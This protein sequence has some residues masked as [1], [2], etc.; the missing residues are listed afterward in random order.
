MADKRCDRCGK[1]AISSEF[2]FN[3]FPGYSW[4]C[5]D[6]GTQLRK[7]KADK[8]KQTKEI[9]ELKKEQLEMKKELKKANETTYKTTR[10]T[11]NTTSSGWWSD[12]T[13]WEKIWAVI[14]WMFCVVW[15]GPYLLIKGIKTRNKFWLFTGIEFT[16]VFIAFAI[17]ISAIPD[18]TSSTNSFH[19]FLSY[20]FGVLFLINIVALIYYW[21]KLR[22]QED[23]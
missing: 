12:S 23:F 21:V 16:L 2:S 20:L 3:M 14:K 4:V 11:S 9:E 17:V 15:G 22:E 6:C 19:V 8:A 5:R 7:E 18:L 10:S 1:V 13:T